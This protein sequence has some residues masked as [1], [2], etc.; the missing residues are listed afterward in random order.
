M[1]C[2]QISLIFWDKLILIIFYNIDNL[3]AS[4]VDF[5]HAVLR[6]VV[7]EWMI[8][9]HFSISMKMFSRCFSFCL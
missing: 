2:W 6:L 3:F 1:K 8:Y 4:C 7:L 9:S 5:M